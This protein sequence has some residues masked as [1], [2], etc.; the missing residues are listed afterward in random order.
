MHTIVE[1]TSRLDRSA[2][3]LLGRVAQLEELVSQGD[4][5]A[6][7]SY[8]ATLDTLVHVLEH[9]TPGRR[10]ELLTTSQ[11][12]ARLNVSPKTLLRR[13]ARGDLRPAVQR[14]K[15]IRW[16]GDEVGR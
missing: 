14:G 11:M 12:A 3:L 13:K 16:R 2:R 4:E 5:A 7:V 1:A 15:L 8:L 10:G 6:W 9:V